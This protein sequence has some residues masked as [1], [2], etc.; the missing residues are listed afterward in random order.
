M[1]PFFTLRRAALAL[2]GSAVA[3]FGV[4]AVQ[5][6]GDAESPEHH[7]WH[8]AGPFGTFDRGA[9]QRGYQ[10][11]R[12][13]CASCHGMQ[14]LTFRNLGEPGGPFYDP[15]FP[16]PNDNPVLRALA[17]EFIILDEPDASGLPVERPG[18]VADTLPDPY[19]NEAQARG[20][21]GGALP[22]DLSVIVKARHY[23]AD[24]IRSLLLGYREPPADV[25]LGQGLHY[26]PWF[27]GGQIAMADQLTIA[28]EAG[29][30]AYAE[31]AANEGVEAS[32]EQMANDVTE[33][34]VWAS[35]PH[36]EARKRMGFMVL[37]YLTIFAV[38]LW[39]SYKAIW[40][41]VEH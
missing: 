26:N 24:Y 32:V 6:A 7:H 40:R 19:V 16:N 30:L 17:A 35:D 38:L 1:R 8:F 36:T 31:T 25:E 34:L 9:L 41:N 15:D 22:P 12:Q 37:I 2:V 14:F 27:A 39:L 21:N 11:Y 3:L 10:V 18:R 5:A 23:G 20:A 13:V 28:Y 4:A 33:F 29:S